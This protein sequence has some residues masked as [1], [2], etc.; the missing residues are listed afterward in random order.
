MTMRFYLLHAVSGRVESCCGQWGDNEDV[1]RAI[2]AWRI[3][4]SAAKRAAVEEGFE[5]NAYRPLQIVAA[6]TG[7]EKKPGTLFR[8]GRAVW[9]VCPL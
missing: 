7:I 9:I 8:K 1:F 5:A 4:Q 6:D 3:V 2:A